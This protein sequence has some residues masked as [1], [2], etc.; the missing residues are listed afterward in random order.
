MICKEEVGNCNIKEDKDVSGRS[1]RVLQDSANLPWKRKSSAN[2]H[3]DRPVVKS[4]P[5]P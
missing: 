1:R 2:L 3:L 4:R 5:I